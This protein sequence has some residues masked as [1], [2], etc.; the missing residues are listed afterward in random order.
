MMLVTIPDGCRKLSG[1]QHSVESV[2]IQHPFYTELKKYTV[3]NFKVGCLF[4]MAN[5]SEFCLRQYR[6][7][8]NREDARKWLWK[9]RVFKYF[10]KAVE[11]VG[12]AFGHQYLSPADRC[13]PSNCFGTR[14]VPRNV[15][16]VFP[17]YISSAYDLRRRLKF[18]SKDFCP[19]KKLPN[20]PISKYGH[21]SKSLVDQIKSLFV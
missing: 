3:K 7:K 17:M 14:P 2:P 15:D 19:S 4:P 20:I 12:T 8:Y 16:L 5:Q 6:D 10:K 11:L 21:V 9:I 18:S 1:H 13:H